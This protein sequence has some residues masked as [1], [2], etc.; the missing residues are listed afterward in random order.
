M[1]VTIRAFGTYGHCN[2]I[3]KIHSENVDIFSCCH[4]TPAFSAPRIHFFKNI[5]TKHALYIISGLLR[6]SVEIDTDSLYCQICGP[7]RIC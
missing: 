6:M 2:V 3:R 5:Q 7:P 4:Y 1:Y